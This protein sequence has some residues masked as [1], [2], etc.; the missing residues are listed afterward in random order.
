[1]ILTV[2]KWRNG[3]TESYNPSN[4]IIYLIGKYVENTKFHLKEWTIKGF[5]NK[6]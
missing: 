6:L 3:S 4:S 2:L 1:M 5:L